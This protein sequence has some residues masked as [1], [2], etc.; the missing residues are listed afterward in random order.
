MT[1]YRLEYPR[2]DG[3]FWLGHRGCPLKDPDAYARKTGARCT[4][5]E[6]CPHCEAEH[7]APWD[8]SCLLWTQAEQ[9]RLVVRRN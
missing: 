5:V 9:D 1:L 7:P 8:G 6:E 3:T 2:E 4:P